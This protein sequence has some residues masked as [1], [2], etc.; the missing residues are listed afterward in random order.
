[1]PDV[2]PTDSRRRVYGVY[3]RGPANFT[4]RL[5][6]GLIVLT[7]GVMWT[8][9]NLGIIDSAPILRWWPALLLAAGLARLT[10]I[11]ARQSVVSG[12]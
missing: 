5:V 10:G 12:A 9:D 4:G 2:Q 3:L 8:L 11:G 1:M 6:F 7:L